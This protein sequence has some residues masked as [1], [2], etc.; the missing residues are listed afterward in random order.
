MVRDG[1]QPS[2]AG[3]DVPQ[4]AARGGDGGRDHGVS[5]AAR[6]CGGLEDD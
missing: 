5:V 1:D 2:V 6:A 3:A 4:E